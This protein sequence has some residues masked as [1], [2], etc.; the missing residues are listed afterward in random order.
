MAARGAG[1]VGSVIHDGPDAPARVLVVDDDPHLRQLLASSLGDEGYAVRTAPDGAAALDVV[2]A[3]RPDLILLDLMMPTMNGWQF[4][5]AYGG[6][7]PPHAPVVVMTAAGP[8]AV[9]S[10]RHLGTISAVLAKPLD[11]TQLHET[12]TLHLSKRA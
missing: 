4:A 10:A 2:R 1:G 6:Q 12:I 9:Q 11:L 5:E 3:W 7:A 8:G